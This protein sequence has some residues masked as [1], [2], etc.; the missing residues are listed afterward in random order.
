MGGRSTASESVSGSREQLLS[1]LLA[2]GRE[3]SDVI[4]L[5]HTGVAAVLGLSATETKALS[6]LER[7]GPVTHGELARLTG[8]SPASVTGLLQRLE[9]RGFVQRHTDP[10]DRRRQVVD[11]D[12]PRVPE[13]EQLFSDL[14]GSLR[15]LYA[16]FSSEDLRVILRWLRATTGVQRDATARIPTDDGLPR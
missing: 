10:A 5:F 16:T 1:D 9:Q 6:V 14:V 11:L 3:H 4:V 15:E 2:A 7:Q 8:L 12:Q 13:V